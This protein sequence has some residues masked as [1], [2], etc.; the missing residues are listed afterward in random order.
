M[1]IH[2]IAGTNINN[3]GQVAT[4]FSEVNNSLFYYLFSSGFPTCSEKCVCR[5]MLHLISSFIPGLVKWFKYHFFFIRNLESVTGKSNG[6]L[7]IYVITQY[8]SWKETSVTGGV[9][10]GMVPA[11]ID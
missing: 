1:T 2:Y 4:V 11:T 6:L 3:Q 9:V 8:M 7:I 10:E 5:N